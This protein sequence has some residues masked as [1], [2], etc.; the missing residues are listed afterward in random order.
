MLAVGWVKYVDPESGHP[1]FYNESTEESTYER[2]SGFSTAPNPFSSA[3]SV[4]PPASTLTARRDA[5]SVGV[6]LN[7]GWVKYIDPETNYPYYYHEADD[8]SQYERPSGFVTSMNPF[9]TV[10]SRRN[11]AAPSLAGLA[12][13]CPTSPS[14][15][16]IGSSLPADNLDQMM[17]TFN[18]G[19]APSYSSGTPSS[20]PT[21]GLPRSSAAAR[22]TAKNLL[23]AE[24]VLSAVNDKVRCNEISKRQ[25]G[26]ACWHDFDVQL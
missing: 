1:Y 2:P 6:Q 16:A 17:A 12:E 22:R 26:K 13:N 19:S 24:D 15:V 4:L 7:G 23:N 18:R 20:V 9:G 5:S 10:K 14:K 11:R 21:L 25:A 8:V 3:R